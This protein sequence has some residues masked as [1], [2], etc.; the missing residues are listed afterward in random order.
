MVDPWKVEMSAQSAY[1]QSVTLGDQLPDPPT[2]PYSPEARHARR[3]FKSKLRRAW[4]AV[5]HLRRPLPLMPAKDQVERVIVIHPG[6]IRDLVFLEPALRALRLRFVKSERILYSTADAADLY[7]G[8]GWGEIRP[9]ELL[10]NEHRDAAENSVVLDFTVKAEY[11]QAKLLK[12]THFSHRVGVNIGGRGAFYNIPASPPL[13]TEHLIDFYLQLTELIGTESMG[14][15]P[16]LPH[17][18]DRFDRG[19]KFWHDREIAHPI[20]LLPEWDGLSFGWPADVFIDIGRTLSDQQLVVMQGNDEGG[21]AKLVAEALNCP[22]IDKVPQHSL[23][24]ALATAA[25]VVGNEGGLLHL[26]T[27]L[28]TPTVA[29]TVNPHPRRTWP[30][31]QA[32]LAVYRGQE[33]GSPHVRFD[34]V[35]VSDIVATA[36]RLKE[37]EPI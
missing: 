13:F 27:A 16:S 30:R 15:V 18:F 31:S 9:L 24:D 10:Q 20:I 22:L 36:L 4:I 32:N 19:R 28:D 29:L 33:A 26:A 17:G 11:D 1:T 6:P 25:L 3:G 34:R 14:D 23:M 12:K 2:S 35:P 7:A 37:M 5:T 8:A 21:H